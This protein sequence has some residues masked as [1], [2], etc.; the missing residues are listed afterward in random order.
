MISNNTNPLALCRNTGTGGSQL[1]TKRLHTTPTSDNAD[2]AGAS[3]GRNQNIPR[4]KTPDTSP[5]IGKNTPALEAKAKGKI[6]T[7]VHNHTEHSPASK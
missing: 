7:N 6:Y 1:P 3:I 4:A 5:E 2:T